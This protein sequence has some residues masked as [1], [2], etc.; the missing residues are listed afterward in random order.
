[1]SK[2][3]DPSNYGHYKV[4][5]V[6]GTGSY[7]KVKLATNMKTGKKVALKFILKSSIKKESHLVRIKREVRLLKLLHHPNIVQLYEASETNQE[8]I[9]TMEH[10]TGGELFDYIV[11]HK[12]IREPE[13]RRLFRQIISA[14]DYCHQNCVIHRDLKPENLLLDEKRNIK[15]IDFG[16]ANTFDP[17]GMLATFCG[18]PYYASPE[19]ITGQKYIGPEVDIWSLGI[20]LY[21]MLCGFLP[22]EDKHVKD[23]YRKILSGSYSFPNHVSPTARDLISKMIVVPRSGRIKLSDLKSHPWI[24]E[25]YGDSLD[26]MMPVR[27]MLS[28]LDEV[29]LAK[30]DSYGYHK[31]SAVQKI[32]ND[33]KSPAFCAYY[34][35]KERIERE[36][37]RKNALSDKSTSISSQRLSLEESK[38]NETKQQPRRFSFDG[39]ANYIKEAFSRNR[40]SKER[41]GN[42]EANSIKELVDNSNLRVVNRLFNVST[43]SS[44]TACK[45][46]EELERVLANLKLEFSRNLFVFT[47][48]DKYNLVKMEIEICKIDKI[49]LHGLNFKRVEGDSWNYRNLCNMITQQL[50]I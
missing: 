43:T 17:D 19:M 26:S 23:L 40:K 24:V 8:I 34:L 42:S 13:A 16:F 5:K 27:P 44:K 28:Q 20:I 22:F 50:Q 7:G 39:A 38:L 25:N 12:R 10:A 41:K 29:I 47:C 3:A 21:V 2:K 6:L 45:L 33:P 14:V 31:E 46:V 49:S 35:V 11:A 30:L 9:L 18:S 48:L 32:L 1:M 37:S 36:I 15:I 4:E